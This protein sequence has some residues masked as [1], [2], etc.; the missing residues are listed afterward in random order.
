M[1]IN[2]DFSGDDKELGHVEQTAI[3]PNSLLAEPKNFW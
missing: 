3:T 2:W 1:E